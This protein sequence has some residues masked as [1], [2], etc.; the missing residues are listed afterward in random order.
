[1]LPQ[2]FH[3]ITVLMFILILLILIMAAA[4]HIYW[5]LLLPYIALGY[6]IYWR[7]GK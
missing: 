3:I 4:D 5:L 6:E 1:M 7:Q 2:R